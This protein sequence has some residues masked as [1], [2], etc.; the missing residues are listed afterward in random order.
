VSGRAAGGAA[1]GTGPG[2]GRVNNNAAARASRPNSAAVQRA[3]PTVSGV[4][5]KPKA[6]LGL[7]GLLTNR[8][9]SSP[10]SLSGDVGQRPWTSSPR[11]AA[12]GGAGGVGLGPSSHLQRYQQEQQQRQQQDGLQGLHMRE[13]GSTRR[14]QSARTRRFSDCGPPVTFGVFGG[15]GR[16]SPP[17]GGGGRVS[18]PQ[19]PQQQQQLPPRPTSSASTHASEGGGFSPSSS[20]SPR[21]S[22]FAPRA[23]MNTPRVSVAG[24]RLS[25]E[26]P[27]M[28]P[29]HYGFEPASADVVAGWEDESPPQH[30]G[31]SGGRSSPVFIH[32]DIPSGIGMRSSSPNGSPNALAPGSKLLTRRNSAESFASLT[33]LD[34]AV[35]EEEYADEYA[36]R[37][38]K[39]TTAAMHARMSIPGRAGTGR[40]ARSSL[41]QGRKSQSLLKVTVVEPSLT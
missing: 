25:P 41:S 34:E 27:E 12:G 7:G 19:P 26:P 3:L 4:R 10:P 20:L 32:A 6:G 14:A 39:N 29:T 21:V 33:S 8:T 1:N 23:P 40:P 11:R 9:A 22:Y 5:L 15:G 35:V 31:F 18:P 17:R 30:Q 24:A 37:D 2:T 36:D 13:H 16:V 28:S 38:R